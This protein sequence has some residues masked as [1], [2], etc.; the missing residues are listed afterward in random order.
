MRKWSL[1]SFAVFE[2]MARDGLAGVI[3]R[4]VLQVFREPQEDPWWSEIVSTFRHVEPGAN[5]SEFR[6]AFSFDAPVIDTGR[7]L[8]YLLDRATSGGALIERTEIDDLAAAGQGFDVIANCSGL[9]SRELARDADLIPVRGEVVRTENRGVKQ[10]LIDE[11]APSGLTYVIPRVDD[12]VLGGCYEEHSEDL[13][14]HFDNQDDIKT[15]CRKLAPELNGAA[16]R[17]WAVGLRPV[18][19]AVRLECEKLESGVPVV[20]NY[21]HGGAGVTLSWGCARDVVDLVGAS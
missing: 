20:H 4:P 10:V 1:E 5:R 21:G 13:N 8:P 11:L 9:G 6:D 14:P 3:M 18:R 16:E 7:F 19:Y 2:A 15:R 12:C 17:S